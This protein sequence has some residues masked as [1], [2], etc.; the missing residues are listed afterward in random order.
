[1]EAVKIIVVAGLGTNTE[2]QAE[3]QVRELDVERLFAIQPKYCPPSS[4]IVS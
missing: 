1:M 2:L 3:G 4:A